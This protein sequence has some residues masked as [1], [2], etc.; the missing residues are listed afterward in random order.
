MARTRG[1]SAFF[2]LT[3]PELTGAGGVAIPIPA[4]PAAPPPI[5]RVR[6]DRQGNPISP[7]AKHLTM[8]KNLSGNTVLHG[9][10]M[11]LPKNYGETIGY[12]ADRKSIAR[13]IDAWELAGLLELMVGK[14]VV[15]LDP[16]QY[17]TLGGDL[18]RHFLAVRELDRE[19]FD[20]PPDEEPAAAAEEPAV[21]VEPIPP[22]PP[23]EPNEPDE[24][25]ELEPVLNQAPEPV[26]EP[27][28]EPPPPPPSPPKVAAKPVPKP[29]VRPASKFYLPVPPR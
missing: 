2:D 18:R 22:P 28:P 10:G 20:W 25:D 13:D 1:I 5:E 4:A 17:A 24:P 7:V 12:Q 14:I 29:A 23:D 19:R 9:P 3:E 11:E 27:E 21:P 15:R 8:P 16:D 6:L 26:P